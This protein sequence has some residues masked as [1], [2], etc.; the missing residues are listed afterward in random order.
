MT[1]E[2]DKDYWE[3]HWQ[4]VGG[5]GP[6]PELAPNPYL[7]RETRDL[8][9]G[10]ALDAGCGEA[11]ALWLAAGWQVTAADISAEALSRALARGDRST[12]A[13]A[14]GRDRPEHMG[15]GGRTWSP[16]CRTG[17]QLA[18]YRR[19]SKWVAPVPLLIVGHLHGPHTEGHG[20][21]HH[22]PEE[23]SATRAAITADLDAIRWDVVAADEHV[24]ALTNPEGRPVQLHDVVVRA[25]RLA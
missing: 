23:A 16:P 9:P 25:T 22:P 17:V 19:L 1:Q 21:E 10:T 24:R 12:G 15:S 2:F 4:Q 11:E 13:G 3:T 6:G 7:A 8:V 20:H 14:M 5:H 18:F